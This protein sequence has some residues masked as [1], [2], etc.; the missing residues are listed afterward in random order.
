M[1]GRHEDIER[2]GRRDP[3][4]ARPAAL[5]RMPDAALWAA[6]GA[7]GAPRVLV[8]VEDTASLIDLHRR[9]PHYGAQG[10]V[11]FRNGR[12]IVSGVGTIETPRIPVSP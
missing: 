6:R 1:I 10:H 4:L 3:R 7:N 11:G 2:L 5:A 9:A 8:S 12:A